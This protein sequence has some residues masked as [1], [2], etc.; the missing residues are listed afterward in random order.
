MILLKDL[1][2][3]PYGIHLLTLGAP[4]PSE[5]HYGQ[6]PELLVLQSGLTQ[7]FSFALG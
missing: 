5:G 7:V 4:L 6:M 1:P 2:L 3:P